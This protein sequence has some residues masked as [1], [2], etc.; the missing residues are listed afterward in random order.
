MIEPPLA[1]VARPSAR[2]ELR[3]IDE[4]IVNFDE[5]IEIPEVMSIIFLY[6]L[7]GFH[8]E[9]FHSCFANL[10]VRGPKFTYYLVA[11]SAF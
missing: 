6:T 11:S 5:A 7:G 10:E 4:K 9:F 1:T 8:P 2:E 3:L